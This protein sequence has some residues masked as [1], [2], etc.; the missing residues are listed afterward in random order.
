[1]QCTAS[2]HDQP[3]CFTPNGNWGNCNCETPP[4]PPPTAP[5]VTPPP[6]GCSS[7]RVRRSWYALSTAE[8]QLYTA[9]VV[10]IAS[11]AAGNS[12]RDRYIVLID[13]HQSLWTSG[14]IHQSW[15]FLPWHRWYLVQ[16][17]NLF[18]EVDCS[19]TIPYWPW[20][21]ERFRGGWNS[22]FWASSNGVG[23][24]SGGN[25]VTNGPFR[26]SEFSITDYARQYVSRSCLRRRRS[27]SM[28]SQNDVFNAQATPSWQ[29]SEYTNLID[30][31][32]GSVHCAIDGT[33]CEQ[34]TLNGGQSQ[35]Q[36]GPFAPHTFFSASCCPRTRHRHQSMHVIMP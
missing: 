16:L 5:P 6:G 17:E 33:M 8:R 23:S 12:L 9:T 25:C 14:Q 2:D 31:M 21:S 7:L 34:I 18:R 10:Q 13:I 4:P 27:G 35:C 28:P 24:G 3:W 26:Q 36:F 32:H 11:G 15:F 1:M 30:V 29:F 20:E 22:E 19:I